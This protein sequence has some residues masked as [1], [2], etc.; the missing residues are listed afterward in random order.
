MIMAATDSADINHPATP[1]AAQAVG[2]PG[3]V[4]RALELRVLLT[5]LEA[6]DQ[7]SGGAVLLVGEPGIGK[8]RMTEE[9]SAHARA[10]GAWV[11]WGRCYEGDGA[12]AFW[13]WV[14]I[15]RL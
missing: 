12:P 14:Q 6:A 4:G 1:S 10:Q 7:G 9:L 15:I 11:L 8:T 13:P 2:Q 3:F 5:A